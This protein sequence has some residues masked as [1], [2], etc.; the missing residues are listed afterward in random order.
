M[1]YGIERVGKMMVTDKQGTGR[2]LSHNTCYRIST[3]RHREKV[4]RISMKISNNPAGISNSYLK[5][6]S[7]VLPLHKNKKAAEY[8]NLKSSRRNTSCFLDKSHPVQVSKPSSL[9]LCQQRQRIPEISHSSHTLP[10]IH[11][12][13]QRMGQNFSVGFFFGGG[14]EEAS[15]EN[16]TGFIFLF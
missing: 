8:E 3:W 6:N 4:L 9:Y 10:V 5:H 13:Q 12:F 15:G 11:D 2:K 1:L 7:T 16:I 14:E